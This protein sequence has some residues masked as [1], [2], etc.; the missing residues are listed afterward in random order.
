MSANARGPALVDM[1]KAGKPRLY[2]ALLC[3]LLYIRAVNQRM[4]IQ[5]KATTATMPI[6]AIASRR[7]F[8]EPV[9]F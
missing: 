7:F 8:L 9:D 3:A 4:N 5:P 6:A 2:S 1:K